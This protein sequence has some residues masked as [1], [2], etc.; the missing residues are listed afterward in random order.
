MPPSPSN[1][2]LFIATKLGKPVVQDLHI[3]GH[4]I[5]M[6]WAFF[7]S[8]WVYELAQLHN[9]IV[10]HPQMQ[11]QILLGHIGCIVLINHASKFGPILYPIDTL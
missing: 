10:V 1:S 3:H 2:L 5:S 8:K 7:L 4:M 9:Y 11:Y 6:S